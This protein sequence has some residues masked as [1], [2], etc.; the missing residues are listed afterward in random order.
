MCST[1]A[2]LDYRICT[3]GWA[4]F[5]ATEIFIEQS[6]ENSGKMQSVSLICT[7]IYIYA[8]HNYNTHYMAF[9]C[10][11]YNISNAI[12]FYILLRHTFLY[13]LTIIHDERN[14]SSKVL[15]MYKRV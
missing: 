4:I 3:K 9:M 12:V 14:T 8:A 13:T 2:V 10:I 6:L 1:A 11:E 15:N 5:H 7:Y